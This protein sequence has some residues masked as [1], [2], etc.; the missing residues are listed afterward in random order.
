VRGLSANAIGPPIGVGPYSDEANR[1]LRREMQERLGDAQEL[2]R[3]FDR[4]STQWQSL[5][6]VIDGLRRM[7]NARNY[8]D[9]EETARLKQAIDLLRQLEVDLSRDLARLQQK[10]KYFYSDD[11][12]APTNY[13]K[14]VDEYYKSLAKG[15][16]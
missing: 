10:E 16:P 12:E 9:P 3:L 13:K 4:N 6:Q 5:E 7:N 15:K 1:Q 11:N 14:L 2:R 8:S